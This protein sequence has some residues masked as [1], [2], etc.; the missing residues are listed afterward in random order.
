[1]TKNLTALRR[2]DAA[3]RKGVTL[4]D[5]GLMLTDSR[6]REWF[7]ETPIN[8]SVFAATGGDG[9][10]YCLLSVDGQFTDQSPVVMVV[11]CNSGNPR[12]V[13]GDSLTDFLSLDCVIG[14]FFLEQLVYKLNET[15]SYLFNYDAFVRSVYFG[16]DP[17]EEDL[18]EL[19]EKRKLLAELS[20][21][22]DLKPWRN[23]RAKLEDLQRR[24]S[25]Q[26]KCD[27]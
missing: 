24:W 2:F 4:S 20:K 23:P 17:A 11:P 16:G 18:E 3:H 9:V 22:F 19:E 5:I 15:I 1:M 12:L 7:P 13:V 21:E 27:P 8:S 25:A 26:I 6:D 14:Y 10:H